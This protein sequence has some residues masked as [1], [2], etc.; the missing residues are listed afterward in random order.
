L[1][2]PTTAIVDLGALLA[3]YRLARASAPG[4]RALAVVKADAYGHGAVPVAR[5][6]AGEADGFAVACIEEAQELRDSGITGPLLLLEGVFEPAELRLVDR[7]G[8]SQVVHTREQ[9]QWLLAARPARPVPVWLKIDTGMHRLGFAPETARE[10][11][12]T[13]A[14]APQVASVVLMTHLARAD[15][16]DEPATRRQLERFRASLGDLRPAVSL[17]NSAGVLGWPAAHG[18]WI[19]PGIMLYGASPF[20]GDAAQG[21]APVMQLTSAI[22]AVRELA[23]GEGIGYGAR[24]RCTRSTRVGTVAIGYAD[25]Y[26]R[27]AADGTPVAAAGVRTRLI[28]RVSMDMVTVDLTDIPDAGIGAPVELWGRTVAANEVARHAETIAY[29]L[30]TGVSRRVPRRYLDATG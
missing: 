13:L 2:R 11:Y 20:G 18:D 9:V 21:L 10:M 26:P 7:L 30:F 25:G 4:S 12:A 6:L 19:R 29:Q 3:N 15:E 14:A 27:H 1:T 23:A 8:L 28:G 24:Y 5:A 22:I 17:A 16:V